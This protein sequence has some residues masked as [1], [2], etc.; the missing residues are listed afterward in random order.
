M[1]MTNKKAAAMFLELADLLDLAGELPFKSNSYKKVAQSLL[2]LDEPFTVVVADNQ[3]EK[4]PGAG[5]AIKEKL[6]ALAETGSMPALEK[7]RNHEMAPFYPS[8]KTYN[9]KPRP[10]GLLARKLKAKDFGELAGKLK[11]YDINQLSGQTK[12]IAIQIMKI[13]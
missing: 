9:L 1:K 2:D 10:L 6:K 7:W 5:K 13:R 3:F 8:L 12:S 11:D 4:I